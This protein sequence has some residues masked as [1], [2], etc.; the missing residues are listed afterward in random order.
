MKLLPTLAAAALL[1]LQAG[2]HATGIL[3]PAYF[4]PSFDPA[5]SQWDEMT[6]AAASGV[7]VT[8]I[9]NVANG[10]GT[11]VNS[12]YVAAVNA[13]KAAGGTVVG[14]VYTCD[15]RDLCASGLPS[16]RSTADVLAD[17]Q[18][19]ADW[20]GVD[21]IFLDEMSNRTSELP[22]YATVAAALRSAHPTRQIFGN[23]GTA[24]PADYLA[25]ADTLITYEGPGDY[26]GAPQEPW[27]QTADPQR[28]AHLH[29]NVATQA[30][31]LSLLDQARQRNAGYVYVT[32]DRY[33]P[34]NDQEPNPWDQLPGYW[35]AEVAAVRASNA[36]PEP[37]T[38]A[39]LAAVMAI[40]TLQ[41]ASRSHRT[42]IRPRTC[43]N[44]CSSRS[45]T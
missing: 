32:D 22:F 21:G 11:A 1:A 25:V 40:T 13:F 38:L 17:V 7:P 2:A 27:M 8:A 16:T 15:G 6:A 4:Y 28:Q 23:P 42:G 30:D 35:N 5:Q 37:G 19:Y 31:M 20:Y 41:A 14:Y 44:P 3:V 45:R 10:P 24:T 43:H 26:T 36:V 39:L 9:M 12:D 33:T 29:Y 34:G 18:R